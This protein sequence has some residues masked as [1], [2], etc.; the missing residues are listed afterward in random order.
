MTTTG[1]V[2]GGVLV[3]NSGGHWDAV[4]EAAQGNVGTTMASGFPLLLCRVAHEREGREMKRG[5]MGREEEE[6]EGE[7]D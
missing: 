5:E 7:L 1:A 3:D 2:V 4:V 6:E